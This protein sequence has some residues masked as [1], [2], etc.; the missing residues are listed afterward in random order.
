[1]IVFLHGVPETAALWDPVRSHLGA[2]SVALSLPGFGCP[3]PDGFGATKDEY[4]AWLLGELAAF[5][6]PVDLVGHDWGA[7]LT[8]RVAATA[9][10][11]LR[12][13][14]T[15]GL[16]AMG[17]DYVW[18]DFA[19]IWQAPGDGETFW[20][21]QLATPLEERATVFEAFGLDHEDALVVASGPDEVM[22]TCILDLYRSAEPNIATDWTYEPVATAA[23]GL[24]L[25]ASEDP[26]GDVAVSGR[27]AGELGMEVRTLDGLGH[28][29]ALQAP[30]EAAAIIGGFV[31][32]V[33]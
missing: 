10:E 11:L 1:M 7:A 15:D 8:D 28:W 29:W 14:V 21:D 5:D 9:P 2:E 25:L 18:H 26:F 23:P 13:W 6:E 20:T 19:K 16:S 33:G 12:S 30:A 32:S 22:A 4:L 27:M 24:L 3:R 17:P 31:D